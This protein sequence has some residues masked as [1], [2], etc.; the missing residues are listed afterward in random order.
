M[1]MYS[2]LACFVGGTLFGS[3]GL[4]LLTS[5]SAKNAYV[6]VAAA[7]LRAKDSVMETVTCVQENV[8]DIMAAAKDLNEDRAAKEAEAAAAAQIF[9]AEDELVTEV[10]AED[11]TASETETQEV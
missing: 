10:E 11:E 2:K 9:E 1:S 7:G 5:K 4:N 6:H 3:V 8:S